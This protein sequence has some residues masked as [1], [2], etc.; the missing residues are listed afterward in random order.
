MPNIQQPPGQLT[1]TSLQDGQHSQQPTAQTLPQKVQ[2]GLIPKVQG[3][4][5]AAPHNS[6][7]HNQFSA[8]LQSTL[9]PRMQLPQHSS[10]HVLPPA[11]GHSVVPTLPSINPSVRPQIQVANSSSLNQQVQPTLPNSGQLATANLSHSTRLVLPNAAMQ[12]APLPHPPL[13]D[14]GFQVQMLLLPA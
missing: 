5:S 7:A 13:P 10:N 12:S 3:Q 14:A 4:M 1:Q 11:A 2:T 8:T 6:L 9:Q